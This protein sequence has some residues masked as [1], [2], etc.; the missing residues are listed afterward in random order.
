MRLEPY[1]SS[2]K[3]QM[4]VIIPILLEWRLW[5]EQGMC[6]PLFRHLKCTLKYM[7]ICNSH[8]NKNKNL[9]MTLKQQHLLTH[10]MPRCHG[11]IPAED[12]E[13]ISHSL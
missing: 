8:A 5:S 13:E 4:E 7:F 11:N 9:F 10:A 12:Y 3:F 6:M 2:G 1:D